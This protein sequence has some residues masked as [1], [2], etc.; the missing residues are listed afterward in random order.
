MTVIET[1]PTRVRF[2][3]SGAGFIA[4]VLGVMS[5][6]PFSA[7][8]FY[9]LA[10]GSE[11][12]TLMAILLPLAVAALVIAVGFALWSLRTGVDASA[13]GVVVRAPIGRRRFAWDDISGFATLDTRVYAQLTNGSRVALPGVG[14]DDLPRL[15]AASGT[16]VVRADD[17]GEPVE[18]P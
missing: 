17:A 16:E 18:A 9:G 7:S 10:T 12:T 14:A 2:R 13:E 6:L 4:S 3:R 8:V 11:N 15:V 5:V 1:T